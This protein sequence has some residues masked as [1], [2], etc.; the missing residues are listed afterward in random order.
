MTEAGTPLRPRSIGIGAL[1]AVCLYISG[2]LVILT[3]LPIVYVS[4]TSGRKNGILTAALSFLTVLALYFAVFLFSP[5][6]AGTLS[7]PLPGLGLVSH[8][9]SVAVQLFGGGY[10][11]FFIVVALVLG[12][13]VRRH[14]GLVKGGAGALAAGLALVVLLALILQFSGAANIIT[15]I[16]GYLEFMVSEIARLQ[17][18]AGVSNAQTAFLTDHGQ[19]VASF[20]MGVIPSLVF[21]FALIAVVVNLLFSRRFIRLP[22]LFSGHMWDVAAFRISDFLI[23]AVILAAAAFFAGRYVVHANFLEFIGIN[24]VIAMAAVYFFQGLA[25]T[26]FFLRRVRFPLIKIAVYIFIILFFQTVGLLI[27]GLGLA[28]VWVDFRKRSQRA[29]TVHTDNAE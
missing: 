3:P 15:G 2:L 13:A 7:I 28:D 14:W 5:A 27:V 19:E 10:F 4:A 25:V 9:S 26:A 24:A 18:T 23:W 29:H 8:F 22:H 11:L 12:E 17:Q 1:I 6:S 16:K 20:V 21:V